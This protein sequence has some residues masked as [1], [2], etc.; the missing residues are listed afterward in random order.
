MSVG[1]REMTDYDVASISPEFIEYFVR[2]LVESRSARRNSRQ[3]AW[4]AI[5]MPNGFCRTCLRPFTPLARSPPLFTSLP[6]SGAWSAEPFRAIATPRATMCW[7]TWNSP[8]WRCRAASTRISHIEYAVD[9]LTW[10]YKHRD[11]VGGL[12]FVE[13]PKV[14]RFF[15]GK[16]TPH[17]RLG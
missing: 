11:L 7:Q 4:L 16:L 1:L 3:A 13:E 2:P 14:L 15:F 9:R 5:S 8:G 6:A 12:K 17:R 10:L